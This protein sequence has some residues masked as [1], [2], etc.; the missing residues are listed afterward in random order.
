[1]VPDTKIYW[2]Q[3][4]NTG[5]KIRYVFTEDSFPLQLAVSTFSGSYKV[6]LVAAKSVRS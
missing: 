2:S 6:G 4:E 5:S 1:M 3:P